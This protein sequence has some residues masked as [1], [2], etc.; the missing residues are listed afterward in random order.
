MPRP[1]FNEIQEGPT[2]P[3]ERVGLELPP[4]AHRGTNRSL[5]VV[6][7]PRWIGIHGADLPPSPAA[8]PERDPSPEEIREHC[9]VIREEW[10][11]HVR[12]QRTCNRPER[13]WSVPVIHELPP[14]LA[15]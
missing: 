13:S 9:R 2:N 8:G 14:G 3:G 6:R 10:S 7:E 11:D 1:Q 12:R 4:Y 15:D 5:R